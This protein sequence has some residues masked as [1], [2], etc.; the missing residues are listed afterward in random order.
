MR[1]SGS[2]PVVPVGSASL[3]PIPCYAATAPACWI[4]QVPSVRATARSSST[5]SPSCWS[6]SFP[7]SQRP[8][9]RYAWHYR[10]SNEKAL[11][12]PRWS[13]SGRVGSSSGSSPRSSSRSWAGW[14][15]S[16][17]MRLDPASPLPS[18]KGPRSRGRRAR[19]EMAVHLPP[20][21]HCQHQPPCGA[22]RHACPFSTSDLRHRLQFVF[23]SAAGQPDLRNERHG[24]SSIS[25]AAH[26]GTYHGLSAQFSGDGFANM[27]FEVDAV[28]TAAFQRWT[29]TTAHTSALALDEKA[30]RALL[31]QSVVAKPYTYRDVTPQLVRSRWRATSSSRRRTRRPRPRYRNFPRT[32]SARMRFLGRLTWQAI[33]FDQPIP[34]VAGAFVV[35]VLI[36]T[37]RLDRRPRIVCPICGMSGSPAWITNASASCT[38]SSVSSCC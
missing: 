7:R 14:P 35:S 5:L 20:A 15:G 12:L 6:S 31:V 33:P 13:Y 23:H 10:A 27:G 25:Q 38:A 19:L 21:G 9:Y 26:T 24:T 8:R 29:E 1:Q 36:G 34:L 32:R 11:H 4:P 17:R 3:P 2:A 30:Y 16:V 22:C 37:R 28:P 18:G